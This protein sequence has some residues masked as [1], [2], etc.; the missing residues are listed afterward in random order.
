MLMISTNDEMS[1]RKGDN[2]NDHLNFE[3]FI[4]QFKF[5]MKLT[6]CLLMSVNLIRM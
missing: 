4:P 2:V 6:C 5:D 3:I 1:K